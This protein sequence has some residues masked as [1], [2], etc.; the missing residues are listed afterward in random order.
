MRGG[1]GGGVRKR[2]LLRQNKAVRGANLD[3]WHSYEAWEGGRSN[4]K[5]CKTYN[6]VT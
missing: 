2:V 1:G 4:T 5:G 6:I 3:F